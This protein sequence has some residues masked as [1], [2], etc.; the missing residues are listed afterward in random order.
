M[1]TTTCVTSVDWGSMTSTMLKIDSAEMARTNSSA[2]LDS[3]VGDD[4]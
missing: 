3:V 1:I 4:E 2:L